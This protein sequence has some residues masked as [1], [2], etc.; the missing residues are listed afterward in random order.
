MPIYVNLAISAAYLIVILVTFVTNGLVLYFSAKRRKYVPSTVFVMSLAIADI[1]VAILVMPATAYATL[2]HRIWNM[3]PWTCQLHLTSEVFFWTASILHF[4]VLAIDRYEAV[5]KPLDY[6]QNP[7]K[8]KSAI[9]LVLVWSMAAVASFLMYSV[10]EWPMSSGQLCL[11]RTKYVGL[12]SLTCFYIPL[13]ISIILYICVYRTVKTTIGQ[14]AV[15]GLAEARARESRV[16]KVLLIAIL[17]FVIC[18]SPITVVEIFETL[19]CEIHCN[20]PN[21]SSI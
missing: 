3:A 11:L 9:F 1:C 18:I 20:I 15:S 17:S 12:W 16:A 6:A 7:R 13:I 21:S 4:P 10:V 14:S 19:I 2:N 5:H 8:I